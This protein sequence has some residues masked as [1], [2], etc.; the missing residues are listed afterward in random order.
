MPTNF[1]P[2][3]AI[4]VVIPKAKVTQTFTAAVVKVARVEATITLESVDADEQ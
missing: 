1:H 4:S 2:E 3:G